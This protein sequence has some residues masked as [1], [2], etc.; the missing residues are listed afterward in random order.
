MASSRTVQTRPVLEDTG[1]YLMAWDPVKRKVAWKQREG[2]GSA[3]TLTTAGNLV[4]QGTAGQKF[5]AFRADTG[6]KVWSVSTQGN[7]VPGP[8]SYSI[9]GVQYVAAISSASTGFAAANGMNRLL[10]YKAGGKVRLPAAPPQVAQ[11]LNPPADFGDAAMHARA[12]ISTSA[13]ARVATRAAACSRASPD[14]N[15]SI[16]LNN[17]PLFKAIVVDGALAE[18]GMISFKNSLKEEDA[19]AIRSYLTQRANEL[20]RNPPRQRLRASGPAAAGAR[21]CAGPGSKSPVT[22]RSHGIARSCAQQGFRCN[23]PAPSW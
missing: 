7:V 17:A 1:S 14:L 18:D 2:N 13:A 22:N 16:A 20:K 23:E 5:S 15:Y 19:E 4:F 21:A 9:G 3:G 6:E 11:V 8:I 10:V 12:R